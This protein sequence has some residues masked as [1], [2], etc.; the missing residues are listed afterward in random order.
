MNRKK[1][2]KGRTAYRDSKTGEFITKDEAE[3]NP[4]TTQK[5]TLPEP[6]PDRFIVEHTDDEE[7]HGY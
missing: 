7:S 3:A 1:R 6:D 5:E 2:K 4:D